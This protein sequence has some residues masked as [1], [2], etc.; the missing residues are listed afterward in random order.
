MH[1]RLRFVLRLAHPAL[2]L[3]VLSLTLVGFGSTASAATVTIDDISRGWFNQFGQALAINHG[4]SNGNYVAGRLSDVEMRNFFLFDLSGVTGTI[5]GASLEISAGTYVSSDASE[6]F[7]LFDVTTPLASLVDGTGGLAAFNDLGSGT[8]YGSRVFT[9]SDP[10]FTPV[11]IALNAAALTSL[12]SGGTLF[13]MGGA[14]TSLG[15]ATELLFGNTGFV[16]YK[17]RLVLEMET[18]PEP[19][20]LILLGTGLVTLASWK[21]RR[22]G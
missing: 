20:T 17:A 22:D 6:T 2:R 3:T 13:G 21:R 8:T 18:V 12:L 5:V 4:V 19:A 1:A 14:V 9:A 10:A 7:S 11:T 16:E 15:S